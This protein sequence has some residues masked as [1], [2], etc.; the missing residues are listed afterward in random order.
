MSPYEAH[1]IGVKRENISDN[2]L[3]W[4]GLLRG[5]LFVD[6]DDFVV[7]DGHWPGYG[8]WENKCSVFIS[9]V[10]PWRSVRQV[11]KLLF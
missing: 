4:H 2:I 8:E 11:L 7:W 3:K 5:E 6:F 1:P 10:P 9:G